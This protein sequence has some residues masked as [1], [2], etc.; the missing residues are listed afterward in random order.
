[1]SDFQEQL[2]HLRRRI[3]KIDKKY[4]DPKRIRTA[5]A[6]QPA[7]PAPEEYLAGQEIE[8]EHGHHFE[9]EKLYERHR[10]H[11][12]IGIADLEDLP[13]DLLNPISNGLIRNIPPS[14]WCFLDTETTGLAG[15]SGTYAF[16]VGVGRITPQGFRVRQFFMRDFGEERSQLSA[17]VEHLK[18]FDVLITYNGRTYDQPLLETRFRM[19]RQRPPFAS[20]EHLDLLF[21][22]RRLWNLRFDSCRLVD[23]ENQILG[24]ERQGDLPGEMIPYVYFEYLRTHEI[25]RLI[26]IFHHNAMDILT[27]ACLTAIVPRAFHA[28]N[29]AQF[30]HGAEM[31]GLARWWRQAEQHD[32]ALALFRQAVER[33]LPDELLFRTLWDI[34]ALEKK[35]GR[36]HAALPVL[37]DLAASPNPMRA[38]AFIELAK[39]YEHRERNYAMAL[40]M[41]RNALDLE[42]SEAL[43]R[44]QSRLEKRLTPKPGRLL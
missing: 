30:A 11:G 32:N 16:L 5:P 13:N 23:L 33:N 20:L 9:T 8:T 26:P 44:R 10:R 1:M 31:V 27:L 34:A 22:A 4:A 42:S 14:K 17:L 39:Y 15:G 24:V 2:A 37:T 40:E 43:R 29:E 6:P 19:V 25:F 12:S 38:A 21:G 7:I 3:A 35:L 36:E 28:P 18:Q 41:T